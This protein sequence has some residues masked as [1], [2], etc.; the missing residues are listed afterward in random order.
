MDETALL[1]FAAA[2][3]G[4]LA[5]GISAGLAGWLLSRA[6]HARERRSRIFA[7]QMP[8]LRR[9]LEDSNDVMLTPRT[10]ELAS[11]VA[12]AAL[13][14]RQDAEYG[15]RLLTRLSKW[16]LTYQKVRYG[17]GAKDAFDAA[18]DEERQ[19]LAAAAGAFYKELGKLESRLRDKLAGGWHPDT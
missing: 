6:E 8:S 3:G 9:S 17:D 12:H 7:D 10:R 19:Q 2:F 18:T 5:G 14:V 11:D 1:S 15:Q 16:E 4:A 13:T